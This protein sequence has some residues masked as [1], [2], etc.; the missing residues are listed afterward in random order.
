MTDERETYTVQTS[1]GPIYSKIYYSLG[2]SCDQSVWCASI[3]EWAL[4][5]VQNY[6]KE[7][8][9]KIIERYI[10]AECI[11]VEF[12]ATAAVWAGALLYGDAHSQLPCP[13]DAK[14]NSGVRQ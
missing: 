4:H 14:I 5:T 11:N 6:I 12:V 1:A 7:S 2:G 13:L 9:M 8:T 10:N 3:V